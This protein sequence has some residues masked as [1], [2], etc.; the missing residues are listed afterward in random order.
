[1]EYNSNYGTQRSTMEI[2]T[3]EIEIIAR[4]QRQT[5]VVALQI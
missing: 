3:M 5:S 4:Q 1:M 2:T